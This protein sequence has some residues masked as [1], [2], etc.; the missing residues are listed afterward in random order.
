[1][2]G[3]ILPWRTN[4]LLESEN[5]DDIVIALNIELQLGGNYLSFAWH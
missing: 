4:L 3:V 1:M 5:I 2:A